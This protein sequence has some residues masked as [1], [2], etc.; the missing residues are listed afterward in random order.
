MNVKPDS[1]EQSTRSGIFFCPTVKKPLTNRHRD[2][3]MELSI[4]VY[5]FL[6]K[7]YVTSN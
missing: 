4:L 2:N 3:G 6:L 5:H 1:P 7:D